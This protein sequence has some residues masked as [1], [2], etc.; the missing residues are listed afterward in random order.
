[1]STPTLH[2]STELDLDLG[3]PM[4]LDLRYPGSVVLEQSFGRRLGDI[5]AGG[6][7]D[8]RLPV[9]TGACRARGALRVTGDVDASSLHGRELHLAGGAIRARALSATERIVIGPGDLKVDV[10]IAPEIVIHPETT[11]RVTVIE[12]FN[13]RASTKVKGG[14]SLK[15]YEDLFGDAATF[16]AERGVAPLRR[17]PDPRHPHLGPPVS[18]EELE[19]VEVEPLDGE[20]GEIG[21]VT[22]DDLE[23]LDD[24]PSPALLD[25][26]DAI[27]P[28]DDPDS[29]PTLH[30]LDLAAPRGGPP[31]TFRGGASMSF[32]DDNDEDDEI[33]R[34]T[35]PL[36]PR[37]PT[38]SPRPPRS[39]RPPSPEVEAWSAAVLEG[40]ARILACYDDPPPAIRALGEAAT[41]GP[42]AIEAALIPSWQDL[43]ASHRQER[44]SIRPAV[45]HRFRVL[46]E[47]IEQPP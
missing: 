6:D 2:I 16:L 1:M 11:G 30:P 43:V 19:L 23:P 29:D 24:P 7:L 35:T 32:D 3:D 25:D 36:P 38:P 31:A 21:L 46:S 27:E 26:A 33:I 45:A 8:L 5:D 14:F 20:D 13:P 17:D 44:R 34:P 10:I 15:E 41:E 4:A 37:A 39:A 9:V 28:L 47:L 22:I 40:A 42:E 12:S 18:E